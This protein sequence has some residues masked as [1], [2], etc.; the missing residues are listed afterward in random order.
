MR[1][2]FEE[3]GLGGLVVGHKESSLPPVGRTN[4]E[5]LLKKEGFHNVRGR[6]ADCP[7]CTGTSR[8]TVV[9]NRDT[10]FCF[11]CGRKGGLRSLSRHHN[12]SVPTETP[13][14]REARQLA[15]EF[16]A[17]AEQCERALIDRYQF[18]W[19]RAG[20]ART[21]L[22]YFPEM[23]QAWD[24]LAD[25]YDNE[26]QLGAALDTLNFERAGIWLTDPET[27]EQLFRSWR[28]EHHARG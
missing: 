24:A 10:F 11:R 1:A 17:W 3:L 21:A 7:Y 16:G 26:A 2:F 5:A 13:E 27:P 9:I 6:R 23:P 14:H 4:F 15:Q 12:Y 28:K 20:L 18:L 19:R 8:L 22:S 25:Y